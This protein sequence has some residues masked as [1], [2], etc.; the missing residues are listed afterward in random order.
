VPAYCLPQTV[1]DREKEI[2]GSLEPPGHLLTRL[3]TVY[4]AYSEC[5]STCSNPLAERTCFSFPLLYLTFF[6]YAEGCM[7]RCMRDHILRHF[8]PPGARL[9]AG[10]PA[11]RGRQV[12]P[13]G[14]ATVAARAPRGLIHCA[15]IR[16]YVSV[17]SQQLRATRDR[18]PFGAWLRVL[19]RMF[20]FAVMY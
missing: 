13:R 3:Y 12:R 18:V 11:H 14:R 1:H 7:A 2:G 16:P 17:C 4:M 9:R 19:I 10:V 15:S 6:Y 20:S 8:P 5:L